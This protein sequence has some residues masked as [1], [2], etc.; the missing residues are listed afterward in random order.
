MG[1]K[2]LEAELFPEKSFVYAKIIFFRLKF[3]EIFPN[4]K[5]NTNYEAK[6]HH[7]TCKFLHGFH[8]TTN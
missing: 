8:D 1:K 4:T 3:G 6:P 5:K 7:L 2:S